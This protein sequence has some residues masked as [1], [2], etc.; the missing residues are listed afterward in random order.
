M[1]DTLSKKPERKGKVRYGKIK[2]GEENAQRDRIE[3]IVS[4]KEKK[5]DC[6]LAETL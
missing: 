1:K 4:F 2:K 6:K 3:K 5:S